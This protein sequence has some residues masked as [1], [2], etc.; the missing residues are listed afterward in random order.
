MGRAHTGGSKTAAVAAYYRSMNHRL[1]APDAL[2]FDLDGTLIDS[3]E[4]IV[5]SFQHATHQHLGA[6]RERDQII[7]VIGLSLV[8]EL[9]RIAP[10]KGSELLTTYRAFFLANH[11]D[12]IAE[13]PGVDALLQALTGRYPHLRRGIVTSKSYIS[14]APSFLRYPHLKGTFPTII[15]FEDTERHKPDPGPLFLAAERLGVSPAACWYI[16]DSTH[17]MEAARAAGMLAIGAAWGPYGRVPLLPLTDIVLDAPEDLIA[18]L[19]PS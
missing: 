12:L 13:Y 18:L 6:P 1:P 3:I 17:D 7:P 5:R 14:L 4:L 15:A 19:P 8:E 11:D 9:E 2:L 10:G 16:G